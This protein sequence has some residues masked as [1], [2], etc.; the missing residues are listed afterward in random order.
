MIYFYSRLKKRKY[1]C[2]LKTERD[3]QYIHKEYVISNRKMK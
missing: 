3:D 2:S 1:D